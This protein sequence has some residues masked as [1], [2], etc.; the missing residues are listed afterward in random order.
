[1][2]L[3]ETRLSRE[4]AS[5]TQCQARLI[6]HRQ[7]LLV[8]EHWFPL[9]LRWSGDN[10]YEQYYNS[11]NEYQFHRLKSAIFNRSTPLQISQIAHIHIQALQHSLF[12]HTTGKTSFNSANLKPVT[13]YRQHLRFSPSNLNSHARL[14]SRYT[15]MVLKFIPPIKS[16][17]KTSTRVQVA[18]YDNLSQP[19][20]LTRGRCQRK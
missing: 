9:V 20:Y 3:P 10:Y 16:Q 15:R 7:K 6:P 2:I 14:R 13:E 1:M 19:S 17:S 18:K 11:K 5:P 12:T 4:R 8:K